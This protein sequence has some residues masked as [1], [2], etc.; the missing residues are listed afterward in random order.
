MLNKKI[1]LPFLVAGATMLVLSLSWD[2]PA[3]SYPENI[4]PS[5]TGFE[6]NAVHMAGCQTYPRP[7]P[8]KKVYKPV[9]H[10][11]LTQLCALEVPPPEGALVLQ[12]TAENK[13]AASPAH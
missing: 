10:H 3:V 2:E 13:A 1:I 5:K 7:E 11:F 6:N 4:S 9:I 12:R 8:P